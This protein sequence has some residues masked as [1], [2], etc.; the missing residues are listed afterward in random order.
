MQN[1]GGIGNGGDD[2]SVEV[3]EEVKFEAT[4]IWYNRLKDEGILEGGGWEH[5]YIDGYKK[6]F[7]WLGVTAEI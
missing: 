6:C 2:P 7:Q 4:T 5:I 1:S 3:D